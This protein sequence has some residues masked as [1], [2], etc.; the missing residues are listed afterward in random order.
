MQ[1]IMNLMI[2][3]INIYLSKVE[4]G[5]EQIKEKEDFQE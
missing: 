1:E 2:V 5:E 4:E 3:K